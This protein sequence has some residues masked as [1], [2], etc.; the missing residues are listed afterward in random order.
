MSRVKMRVLAAVTIMLFLGL[1]QTLT[2]QLR[3]AQDPGARGGPAGAGDK[4]QGLTDR[5]KA[6]FT[7]GLADFSG[8][9]EVKDGAGPRFNFVSCAGCH[10][11]P[12]ARVQR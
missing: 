7:A 9:E 5:Q 3:G 8:E 1:S 2:A 6:M 12:A 10:V 4:L 11:Q